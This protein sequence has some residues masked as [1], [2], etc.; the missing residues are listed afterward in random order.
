MWK[1]EGYWWGV[2]GSTVLVEVKCRRVLVG[3]G[4]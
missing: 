2:D 4:R 1:L 3:A